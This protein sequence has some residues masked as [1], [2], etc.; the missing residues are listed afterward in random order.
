M[1]AAATFRKLVKKRQV[2]FFFYLYEW[3]RV[4]SLVWHPGR[5]RNIRVTYILL[6]SQRVKQ[7]KNLILSTFFIKKL[8][9]IF[10]KHNSLTGTFIIP[11]VLLRNKTMKI[12]DIWDSAEGMSLKLLIKESWY[13][14]NLSQ[15]SQKLRI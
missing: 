15:Q 1:T 11:T 8:W 10:T 9:K 14:K 3:V 12:W 4:N 13:N 2:V 7:K 6:S 5:K